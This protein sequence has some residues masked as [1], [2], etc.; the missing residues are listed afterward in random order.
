MSLVALAESLSMSVCV[1]WHFLLL[2]N[3][4]GPAAA[5]QPSSSTTDL[6]LVWNKP[7]H[8]FSQSQCQTT[9]A[10]DSATANELKSVLTRRCSLESA[11]YRYVVAAV[12][13][14]PQVYHKHRNWC[15]L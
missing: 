7:V 11:G 14:P 1:T 6:S 15:C 8:V 9:L 3:A 4:A 13:W 5:P 2:R 10:S 12:R